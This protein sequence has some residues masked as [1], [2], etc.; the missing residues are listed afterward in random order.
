MIVVMAGQPHTF[1]RV[2]GR[3][4]YGEIGSVIISLTLTDFYTNIIFLKGGNMNWEDNKWKWV[5]GAIVVLVILYYIF[6]R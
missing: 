6:A 1:L 4:L 2:A 5:I 3:P